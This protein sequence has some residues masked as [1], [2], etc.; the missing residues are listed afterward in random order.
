MTEV[1]EELSITE[2]V[3]LSRNRQVRSNTSCECKGKKPTRAPLLNIPGFT[4]EYCEGCMQVLN[5]QPV[6][7]EKPEKAKKQQLDFPVVKVLATTLPDQME[8]MCS[9]GEKM[10]PVLVK[11]TKE[12]VDAAIL[13][14]TRIVGKLATLSFEKTEGGI[15]VN[16]TVLKVTAKPKAV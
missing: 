8:F 5:Y 12:K 3:K 14:P 15:P 4:G 10:F 11:S 7:I 2:K 16:A 13:D 1:T 6:V 9:N